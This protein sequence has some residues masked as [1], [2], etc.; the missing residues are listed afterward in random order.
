MTDRCLGIIEV[1]R[2]VFGKNRGC[3]RNQSGSKESADP[4][5]RPRH[6]PTSHVSGSE[7]SGTT[8]VMTRFVG[9]TPCR[10][11]RK[12]LARPQL[13]SAFYSALHS[14]STLIHVGVSENKAIRATLIH[15]NRPTGLTA[16]HIALGP[17]RPLSERRIVSSGRR[18]VVSRTGQRSS[19]KIRQLS[20]RISAGQMGISRLVVTV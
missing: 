11:R 2:H 10:K 12:A 9:S 17:L 19:G 13:Q 14:F 20:G 4:V 15:H 8:L 5:Q 3:W 6:G 18:S 16:G 1:D 7:P